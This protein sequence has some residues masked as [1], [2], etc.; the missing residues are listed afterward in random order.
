MKICRWPDKIFSYFKI[1]SSE[2]NLR[3]LALRFFPDNVFVIRFAC[4]LLILSLRIVQSVAICSMCSTQHCCESSRE[5][6]LLNCT[7][8]FPMSKVTCPNVFIFLRSRWT[9][10]GASFN[11][12]HTLWIVL[13]LSMT[14]ADRVAMLAAKPTT[15][16]AV[17][18][19]GSIT[20]TK[21]W[22]Q[23]TSKVKKSYVKREKKDGTP[24]HKG[25]EASTRSA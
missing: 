20:Y 25:K 7:A 3:T 23:I 15:A 6:S 24:R 1:S 2:K 12:C 10:S 17:A 22:Q 16:I 9:S 19:T 11:E 4:N 14:T 18:E 8:T 5:G 13:Q 21:R